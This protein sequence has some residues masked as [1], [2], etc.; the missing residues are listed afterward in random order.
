MSQQIEQTMHEASREQETR[1]SGTQ[2]VATAEHARLQIDY[3]AVRDCKACQEKAQTDGV[4]ALLISPR[5]LVRTAK[6][7]PPA[8]PD[9]HSPC[10]AHDTLLDPVSRSR[11]RREDSTA[12]ALLND[13]LKLTRRT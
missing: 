3:S 11:V 12:V 10:S 7:G 6:L 8:P 5:A 13:L 4:T 1:K 2:V 9:W